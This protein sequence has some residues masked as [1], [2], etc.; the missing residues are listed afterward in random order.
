MHTVG[1]L[2]ILLS[3]PCNK[4]NDQEDDGSIVEIALRCRPRSDPC[5]VEARVVIE[6]DEVR[7]F[8]CVEGGG[9]C[10]GGVRGTRV[11]I[12]AALATGGC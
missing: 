6:L 12:V 1:R 5:L 2:S 9:M 10:S 3:V 7:I 4:H 8:M 11:E